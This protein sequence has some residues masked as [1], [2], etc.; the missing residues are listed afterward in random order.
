MAKNNSLNFARLSK[1]NFK[2]ISLEE[3]ITLEYLLSAHQK[4]CLDQVVISK[5]EAETGQKRSKIDKAL[6]ELENKGFVDVRQEKIRKY[7]MLNI[8]KIIDNLPRIL[9]SSNR[10]L[11]QYFLFVKNP[12]MFKKGSKK[13]VS[14]K[15]IKKGSDASSQMSLF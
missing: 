10:Y 4:N 13:K 5:I 7:F 1:Y 14:K 11:E 6:E 15:S 9:V 12:A 3:V 2:Y 8:D